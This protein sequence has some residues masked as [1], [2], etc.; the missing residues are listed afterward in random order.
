MPRRPPHYPRS[1]FA[2]LT[3]GAVGL[4]LVAVGVTGD[5]GWALIT[6]GLIAVVVSLLVVG[7]ILAPSIRAASRSDTSSRHPWQP[8]P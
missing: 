7:R 5:T 4:A 8:G 6:P 2:V 1:L 3:V